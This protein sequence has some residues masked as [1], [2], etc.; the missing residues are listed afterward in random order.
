[1]ESPKTVEILKTAILMEKRGQAL[2]RTVA[3]TTHIVEV[4]NIFNLMAQE[5]QMHA[6]Y[7][8]KQL[9]IFAK[10]QSLAN[11]DL[12]QETNNSLVNL[13]LDKELKKKIAA[14]G[15]EA[16]AI[17]AAIDME[18]N[19]IKVYS[20]FAAAATD[21]NEKS[22]FEWLAKWERGHHELLGEI[23]KELKEEIWYD[24]NFWPF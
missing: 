7:L 6:E 11:I 13:I 15:F 24:N 1:M 19:A 17:S 8:A 3:E 14:A 10:N 4:K 16:A 5:E 20:D 9:T 18:S 21:P 23:D 12:P 22:F 2:Y